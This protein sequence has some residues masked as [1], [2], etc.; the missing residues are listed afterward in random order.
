M[1]FQGGG[2]LVKIIRLIERSFVQKLDN[3]GHQNIAYIAVMIF[4]IFTYQVSAQD[5]SSSQ[6]LDNNTI[7]VD[8]KDINTSSNADL[9]PLPVEDGE[10][11]NIDSSPIVSVWDFV[12]MVLVLGVIVLAIYV[13]FLLI[14][15]RTSGGINENSLINVL[16]SRSLGGSRNLHV[17]KVAESFFLIGAADEA[18]NLIAEITSKE[19]KDSLQLSKPNIDTGNKRSFAKVLNEVFSRKPRLTSNK[20]KILDVSKVGDEIPVNS[21]GLNSDSGFIT[22][23]RERLKNLGKST[24]TGN[25]DV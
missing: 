9:T 25:F 1:L 15:R 7:T 2:N 22:K 18:I 13:V 23:Q 19:S 12:R 5:V 16:G 11:R 24:I 10:N 6:S 4:C 14:K 3:I 17:V 20:T 21:Q 8:D